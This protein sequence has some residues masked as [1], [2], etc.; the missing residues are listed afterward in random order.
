MV[1]SQNN[2]VN[3]VR[4]YSVHHKDCVFPVC[5]KANY[6]DK[7]VIVKII[8]AQNLVI[9]AFDADMKWEYSLDSAIR[10]FFVW[11]SFKITIHIL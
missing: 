9:K 10:Q 1:F 5:A 8:P 11:I 4:N 2:T 3:M 6:F 7:Y